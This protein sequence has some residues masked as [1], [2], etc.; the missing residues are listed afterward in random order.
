[1]SQNSTTAKTIVITRPVG[2]ESI[3][4][5]ELLE[6]GY[7]VIHEPI[8]EIFLRHT[9][10]LE[11][12]HALASVPDAVIITSKHAVQALAMLTELRDMFLLCVGE[13]TANIA[14]QLGFDRVSVAGGTVDGI[15]DYILDCYDEDSRFLYISGED[16]SIN[17]GEIFSMRGMSLSRVVVYD[18]IAAESLSDTLVEQLRRGQIDAIS[19]FSS[20]TAQ[21]FL[22]LAE[23]SGVITTLERLDTFCLSESI[24]EITSKCNWQRIYSADKATLASIVSC[25]DNAYGNNQW[26]ANV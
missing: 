5:D 4:R 23:K 12:E 6:R 13:A 16:I 24:T 8:T 7:H 3:L 2:D 20:R 18:A 19:F 26:E 15:I 9:A 25:I 1:M 10:R 21:I 17:L 14:T 22:S 11:V